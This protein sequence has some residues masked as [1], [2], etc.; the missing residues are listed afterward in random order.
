[1][2]QGELFERR[3]RIGAEVKTVLWGYFQPETDPGLETAILADWMDELQHYSPDQVRWG[4]REW[5]REF[6]DKRPNPGHIRRLL[7][8]AY[9]KA[10]L[11]H[12]PDQSP[13]AAAGHRPTAD[14]RVRNLAVVQQLFPAAVKHMPEYRGDG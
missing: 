9:I 1:M 8:S 11:A 7:K 2:P 13:T 6:P 3:T 5:R 14:E 4:L 12:I 10:Q